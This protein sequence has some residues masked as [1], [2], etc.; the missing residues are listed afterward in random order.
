MTQTHKTLSIFGIAVL[1]AGLFG[2]VKPASA[3]GLAR[4]AQIGQTFVGDYAGFQIVFGDRGGDHRWDER[5]QEEFRHAEFRRQQEIRRI[6][7]RRHEEWQR[8][9]WQDFRDGDHQG[10]HQDNHDWHG[11][12]YDWHNDHY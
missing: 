9:H 4:P 6:E 3:A 1:A 5:R 8:D 2:A 12:N 10:W 7:E 11:D